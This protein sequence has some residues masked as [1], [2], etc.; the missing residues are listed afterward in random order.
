MGGQKHINKIPPKSKDNPVS[1]N[2][3]LVNEFW[4]TEEASVNVVC[5]QF[6]SQ[7]AQRNSHQKYQPP[8]VINRIGR[9]PSQTVPIMSH[10]FF[11]SAVVF[12]LPNFVQEMKEQ[13][14]D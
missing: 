13:P 11:F 5:L 10:A 2:S 7:E 3:S 6:F 14:K 12:S 8:G 9:A 1:I 4:G